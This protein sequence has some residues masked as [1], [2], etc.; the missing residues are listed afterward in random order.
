MGELRGQ[1]NAERAQNE[2]LEKIFQNRDPETQK[3][4][5]LVV[6]AIESQQV[7]NQEFL[8]TLNEIHKIVVDESTRDMKVEAKISK[9]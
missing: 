5:E 4:Y 1:L 7:A 2:R 3:F 9:Q 6:R 8:K